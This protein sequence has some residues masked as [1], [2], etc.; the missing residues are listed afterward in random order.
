M[1][2]TL[3]DG[4]SASNVWARRRLT[5]NSQESPQN[6]QA[7]VVGAS[8]VSGWAGRRVVGRAAGAMGGAGRHPASS[9]PIRL[10]RTRRSSVLVLGTGRSDDNPTDYSSARIRIY[11]IQHIGLSMGRLRAGALY[12]RT[13]HNCPMAG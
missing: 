4:F 5:S 8:A 9:S 7:M 12:E 2:W 13:G 11:R 10:S 3:I 1:I 6:D